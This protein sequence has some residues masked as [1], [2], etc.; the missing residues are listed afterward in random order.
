MA[1]AVR[2]ATSAS[3]AGDAIILSPGTSSFD[4]YTGYA[5]RGDV[6]RDAVNALN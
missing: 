5:Q 3:Q 2:L 6:F 4:M 1:D